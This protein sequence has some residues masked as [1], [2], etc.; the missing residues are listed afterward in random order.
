LA[1]SIDGRAGEG[2]V[3][4]RDI[5]SGQVLAHPL[6]HR[7]KV[8][9]VE[10]SKDG[11][12]L[13]TSCDDHH[14]RVWDSSTGEPVTPWLWQ[15][16]KAAWR[17]FSPD[18]ARLATLARRG[19]VRLWNARTGEPITAPIIYSRNTGDGCVAFSPD[20]AKLLLS[21]GGDEAWLRDLQPDT[22][23]IGELK[24][25]AQVLSCTRFDPAAGMVPLDDAS[26]ND[27]WNQ[28]RAL[29]AKN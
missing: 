16:T 29:R 26:L 23:S 18:G 24:L 12:W 2:I 14:A 9:S 17:L 15:I 10:I 13:A 6:V 4:L 8:T 1:V 28:L 25:L 11:R 5:S 3:E 19:A 20:G 21:R 7:E 22:A 27:A